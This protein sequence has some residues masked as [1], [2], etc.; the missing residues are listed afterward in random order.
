M[1]N[2]KSIGSHHRAT[3]GTNVHSPY[4]HPFPQTEG[5]Q[6]T[7]KTRIANCDQTVPD[8]MVVCIDR[9]SL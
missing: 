8:T 9:I 7:V 5:L 2:A 1:V 4:D 6:P 3:Q